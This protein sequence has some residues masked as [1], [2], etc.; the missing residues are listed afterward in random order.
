MR[1][2]PR[3][4]E[5]TPP[6]H[7]GVAPEAEYAGGGR[8]I[9]TNAVGRG[10][11]W[12]IPGSVGA[13]LASIAAV[14]LPLAI[15]QAVQDGLVHRN[16]LA[17][18][19]WVTAMVAIYGLR[20]VA[21]AMRL[22]TYEGS[23]LCEQHL[24]NQVV[25]AVVA[26]GSQIGNARLPGD[27]MSVAVGDCRSVAWSY[28]ALTS[29][30]SNGVT[31][32][33]GLA[34]LAWLDWHILLAAGVLIPPLMALSVFGVKPMR[35]RTRMERQAE[36]RA[37]GTA[38]D[39]A[40]GLRVLQGL[41]AAGAAARRFTAM[42]QRGLA[43]TL[44]T[45]RVRGYYIAALHGSVGFFTLVLTICGGYSALNGRIGL[46]DVVTVVGVGVAMAPPLRALGVDTATMLAAANASGDRIAEVLK[47][48]RLRCGDDRHVAASGVIEFLGVGHAVLESVTLTI[49]D[50]AFV[51]IVGPPPVLA[52]LVELLQ[53]ETTPEVGHLMVAGRPADSWDEATYRR[54]LL[55]A[56]HEAELF[57]GTVRD[58][59]VLDRT[60]LDLDGAVAAAG[61]TDVLQGLPDGL[62]TPVGE[63]GRQLS[64]G[65]RQRVALARALLHAD[66]A[67]ILYD[68]LISVDAVTAWDLA[69]RVR[70]YRRGSTTV[71]LGCALAMLA[72]A[73]QVLLLD[74]RGAVRASGTHHML[75]DDLDYRMWAS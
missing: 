30:P 15:G 6:E 2:W 41:G 60:G 16:L 48:P 55:A 35:Q 59:L 58:N 24:R 17:F 14:L 61:V 21:T 33:G 20:M 57:D 26:P 9:V 5:E 38:A 50:R 64:G 56:P 52:A 66:G 43:A 37:A 68:P 72:Q 53:R 44:A 46:G 65:Q 25:G 8:Q 29:L 74:E 42:S 19:L 3:P 73:D 67:L 70:H 13:G 75:L 34:V 31:L 40:G 51:G 27:L 39:L 12:L 32:L 1:I 4:L 49:P 28:V 11:R 71:V 47:V 36:A 23:Y 62:D 45:R 54:L 69:A 18:A 10:W 63:G 22:R 7:L